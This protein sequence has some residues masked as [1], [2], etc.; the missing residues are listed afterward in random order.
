[1]E[2]TLNSTATASF[3]QYETYFSPSVLQYGFIR[4]ELLKALLNKPQK[5][6]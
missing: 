6:A 3:I 4:Y 2:N 1:M 5:C